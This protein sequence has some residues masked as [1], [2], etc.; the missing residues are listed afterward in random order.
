MQNRHKFGIFALIA[1]VAFLAI[2]FGGNFGGGY[3]YASIYN[4][5]YTLGFDTVVGQNGVDICSQ[6]QSNYPGA[7]ESN[8]CSFRNYWYNDFSSVKE[9]YYTPY[10]YG[11]IPTHP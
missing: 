10:Y 4:P 11:S 8:D 5:N 1:L 9:Y 2:V 3:Q 7:F 6:N